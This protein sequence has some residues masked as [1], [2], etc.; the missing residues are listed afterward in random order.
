MN[1]HKAHQFTYLGRNYRLKIV[2]GDS[3][4]EVKLMNGRF[5][6]QIPLETAQD[7]RDRL[8]VD[9]LRS[10]YRTR[11]IIRL[12]QKSS[13]YAKQMGVVPVAVGLKGYKSQWASCHTDK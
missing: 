12:R 3:T 9:Q 1:H 11:S 2:N 5:Y 10:W 7:Y 8:V 13:M 4:E 6:V